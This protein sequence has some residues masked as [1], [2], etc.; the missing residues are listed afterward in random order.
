MNNLSKSLL[1]LGFKNN[2]GSNYYELVTEPIKDKFDNYEY[3]RVGIH[4]NNLIQLS[5]HRYG[6]FYYPNGKYTRERMVI[7]VTISELIMYLKHF[8]I[9]LESSDNQDF[10][11]CS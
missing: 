8:G 10:G 3:I 4:I 9:D 5:V 2:F 6:F 11:S 7:T 1:K